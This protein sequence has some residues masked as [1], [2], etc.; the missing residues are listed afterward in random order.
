[1]GGNDSN[2]FYGSFLI[3]LC[4]ITYSIYIAG[5]GKVIPLIGSTRFTAYAMLASTLGIFTHFLVS[6]NAATISADPAVW[7][8]GFLLAII[9]TVIP[10][11]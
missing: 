5:S 8:Y 10:S 6:G 2:F 11:F 9:A 3:F 7:K 4:A 1:M